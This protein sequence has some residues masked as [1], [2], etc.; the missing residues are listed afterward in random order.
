ML[1]SQ[2]SL[3]ILLNHHDGVT[4]ALLIL[5]VYRVSYLIAIDE[6]PFSVI[7]R[8]RSRID[9]NQKTWLGRGVRCVGCVSFWVALLAMLLTGG[10]VLDWLSM[11]GG[12]LVIHKA[13]N[14]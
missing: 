10:S 12:A 13:V 7:E 9:E 11:A 3:Q 14:R 4:L 5:A 8:M 2:S 6:G 1:L